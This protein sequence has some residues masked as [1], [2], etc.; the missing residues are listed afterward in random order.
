MI[1]SGPGHL[2]SLVWSVGDELAEDDDLSGM[3]FRLNLLL[4]LRGYTS[5]MLTSSPFSDVTSMT[6]P[7][8]F[9]D[10]TSP[11]P[12]EEEEIEKN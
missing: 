8:L 1:V 11:V 5:E 3:I 2:C 9:R 4:K 12:D 10:V 7:S 6:S